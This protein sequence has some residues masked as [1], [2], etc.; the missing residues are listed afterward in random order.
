[1]CVYLVGDRSI[2]KCTHAR[3]SLLNT[4]TIAYFIKSLFVHECLFPSLSLSPHSLSLSHFIRLHIRT[5]PSIMMEA[6]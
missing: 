1:M 2:Q 6:I 3:P 5:F 4:Y